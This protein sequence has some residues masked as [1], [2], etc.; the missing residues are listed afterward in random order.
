MSHPSVQILQRATERLHE[1]TEPPGV[2]SE[3]IAAPF[4]ENLWPLLEKLY[5]SVYSSRALL[6]TQCINGPANHFTSAWVER[7]NSELSAVLLFRCEGPRVCVLN[8]VL[9]LSEVVIRRF[10]AAVFDKYQHVHLVQLH[11]ISLQ[12]EHGYPAMLSSIFS[13]DYVLDL[14]ASHDAWLASLSRQARE[15]V[16]YH[17][18]RSFRRQPELEFTV[19][20]SENISETEISAVLN[21]NRQRMRRKRKTYAMS[22]TEEE[23]LAEQLRQVGM[24]FALRL[25]SEVCA[26]LLCSVCNG[27]IYMHV[28]AHDPT[29]DELRLGLV[30]CSL[31]IQ[32]AIELR[33]ARF[34]FLWGHYDY[35]RRLGGC[36]RPL[37]RVLVPKS[38]W[39]LLRHPVH[40]ARWLNHV[41]LD[42]AR[43]WRRPAVAREVSC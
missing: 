27:D 16:R 20:T 22:D 4:P 30:C 29:Y 38:G 10:S 23:Q 1:Q 6:E 2:Q 17:L 31:A 40:A 5:G 21:L 7:I 24:L 15:K 34:H 37:Y 39:Y 35:K 8:E 36:V 25:D 43:R 14:P 9:S 18:R 32:R 41:A 26:G 11:A 33:Y 12:P 28:I 19:S 42:T 3:F 13:E